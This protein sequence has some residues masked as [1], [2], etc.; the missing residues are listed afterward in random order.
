MSTPTSSETC[1]PETATVCE[2]PV[3]ASRFRSA[4]SIWLLSPV[5]SARANPAVSCGK[6]REMTSRR[7]CARRLGIGASNGQA[8]GLLHGKLPLRE[9]PKR[10]LPRLKGQV[11]RPIRAGDVLHL[12]RQRHAVTGAKCAVLSVQIQH[13]AAVPEPRLDAEAVVACL[14]IVRDGQRDRALQP[15]VAQK[16]RDTQRLIAPAPEQRKGYAERA[17]AHRPESVFFRSGGAAKQK[18]QRRAEQQRKADR[19]AAR[20]RLPLPPQTQTRKNRQL[21][22]GTALPSY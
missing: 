13:H 15:D 1:R 5:T 8:L 14:R 11:I 16:R 17:D 2:M 6:C 3:I 22:H 18:R 19:A 4:K 10:D 7:A 9:H 12:G 21:P 20:H